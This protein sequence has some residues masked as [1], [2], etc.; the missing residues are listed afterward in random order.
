MV[1]TLLR[2]NNMQLFDS[3][4]KIRDRKIN[5]N[6]K[7]LAVSQAEDWE[8]DKRGYEQAVFEITGLYIITQ[9]D[10]QARLFYINVV[11]EIVSQYNGEDEP[12]VDVRLAIENAK[13]KVV[14]YFQVFRSRVPAGKIVAWNYAPPEFV[15][16]AR[17]EHTENYVRPKSKQDRGIEIVKANPNATNKELQAMFREQLDLTVNGSA[18]Y[19]YNVRR[20]IAKQEK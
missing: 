20:I 12:V 2:K 7:M 3:I 13:Q 1:L 5:V 6:N 8:S 14:K 11:N 16:Q 9:F 15:E 19:V 4:S 17:K 10:M 18:T